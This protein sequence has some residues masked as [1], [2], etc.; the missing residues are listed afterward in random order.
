MDIIHNLVQHDHMKHVD[1]DKFFIKEKLDKKK[2]WI[3]LRLVRFMDWLAN[4]FNKRVSNQVFLKVLNKMGICDIYELTWEVVLILV[5][6]IR[7]V[8]L[9]LNI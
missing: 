8:Q 4:I 2:L 7:I 1:V 6:L 3:F 9:G 5:D